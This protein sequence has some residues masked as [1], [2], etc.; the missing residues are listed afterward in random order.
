MTGEVHPDPELDAIRARRLREMVARPAPASRTA[1][2]PGPTD[3]TSVTFTGF[4]SAHDRV[5][6]D[7][8]AP[9]CGP[10]RAMAPVLD[11]LAREL[12]PS[13]QFG[14]L[15][16]DLEPALAGRFGV[17]GIPTLLI[18]E[19]GRLVDQVVGAVPQAPL[20]RHLEAIYGLEAPRGDRA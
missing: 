17:S 11:S 18:F 12:A 6:V 8:W 15:N 14:K 5:V 2:S 1:A 13:V 4:L 9:W 10:C 3:L 7:V 16:A 20:R 19:K